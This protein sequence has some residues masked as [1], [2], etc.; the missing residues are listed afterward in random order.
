ML[1]WGHAAGPRL[2]RRFRRR[3]RFNGHKYGVRLRVCGACHETW[4]QIG[5]DGLQIVEG[6]SATRGLASY[7]L[8]LLEL[9]VDFLPRDQRMSPQRNLHYA[10][11]AHTLQMPFQCGFS[12]IAH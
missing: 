12:G 7:G 11:E 9:S 8:A 2:V 4:C 10:F 1:R 3:L 5:H 6:V